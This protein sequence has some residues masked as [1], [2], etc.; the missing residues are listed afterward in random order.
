MTEPSEKILFSNDF[1]TVTTQRVTLKHQSYTVTHQNV[2]FTH[3]LFAEE[4]LLEEIGYISMSHTYRS[5]W[6][7]AGILLFIFGPF[8]LIGL[9]IGIFGLL[10]YHKIVVST[11]TGDTV[12]L[13][14]GLR[15]A[16]EGMQF[17]NA[18]N[19]ALKK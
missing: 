5:F 6:L 18:V 9:A 3:D 15:K 10:G 11:Y 14:V 1:G 12:P 13:K 8:R 19:Q 17:I 2:P 4:I 7:I 16:K